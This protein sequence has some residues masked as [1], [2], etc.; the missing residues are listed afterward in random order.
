MRYQKI[1]SKICRN[2]SFRCLILLNPNRMRETHPASMDTRCLSCSFLPHLH[3]ALSLA[4]S[5]F[6]KALGF[7]TESSL[8]ASEWLSAHIAEDLKQ[9]GWD[10]NTRV[11]KLPSLLSPLLFLFKRNNFVDPVTSPLLAL[12][13]KR[14]LLSSKCLQFP[15]FKTEG[16]QTLIIY[17]RLNETQKPT[18]TAAKLRSDLLSL[19]FPTPPSPKVIGIHI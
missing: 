15:P 8:Q 17:R 2:A 6:R 10:K 4:D 5:I 18:C 7:H 11:T 14:Y 12:L 3:P 19:S 13:W 16:G 1:T 9:E